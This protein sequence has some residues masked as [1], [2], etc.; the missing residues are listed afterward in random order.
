M[1][2]LIAGRGGLPA[3]VAA[4]QPVPPLICALEGYAPEGLRVD[5]E[6]R[7][8]TI[9]TLIA[10]LTARGVRDVCFCGAIDRPQV[11]PSR[12]DA[13]TAPL[14]P[15]IAAAIAAGE[16]GALRGA[17]SLFETAG[18]RAHAA[19]QLA[20]DLVLGAGHPTRATPPAHAA[21]DVAVALQVLSDQ[22][23]AD[24]GQACVIEGGRVRA[25]EDTRGTD[26]MLAQLSA[27]AAPLMGE[28]DVV[29]DVMDVFGDALGDAA[30]WLT[31]EGTPKGLL[32]K[33]PKPDQDWRVD[34]PTIGPTTAQGAVKAGLGGIVIAAGGVIVLERA[35]VI[36]ILDAAGLYLWVR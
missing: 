27:R 21:A 20:P 2:A 4:A 23:A 8:E 25:R 12:I 22:S 31:G 32:F 11:D 16:D 24:M 17:I 13:A 36:D 5:L 30:D 33:A 29:S 10:D 19:H 3:A 7:I 15:I 14:V 18:L 6:F 35:R 28:G 34:L 1:L 9:G 26:W